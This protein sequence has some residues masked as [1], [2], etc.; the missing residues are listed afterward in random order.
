MAVIC[1][2]TVAALSAAGCAA[3]VRFEASADPLGVLESGS[4]VYAR[5]SGAAARELAPKALSAAQAK[6]LGPVLARTRLV[7]LGIG[8]LSAI[9]GTEAPAFQACLIGDYPFRAAVLSLGNDPAWKR[10]K[11]GFFN[12]GLGL[13]ASV[14]GPGIV[15]AS[16]GKLEGLLASAKNPG[17]SPI[18]PKLAELSSREL[19]LWVPEPFSGLVAAFLGEAMDLPARGFIISASPIAPP[20]DATASVHDYEATIV[21][22]MKDADSAR[23]Y[24]PALRLAWY[25]I[26]RFLSGDEG[27]SALSAAFSLDG[28]MYR[29]SGVVLSGAALARALGALREVLRD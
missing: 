26:A 18:P 15:L 25:G 29:A 21:F 2:C 8:S 5:L 7:A 19:V 24:R 4:M 10:E 28:D 17:P 13:R 23:I 3:P 1:A 20:L 6:A 12:A 27:E 9:G 14:P 16:S 11:T 22:L